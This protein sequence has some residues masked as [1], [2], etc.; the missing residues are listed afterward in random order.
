M[1]T[2]RSEAYGGGSPLL[3]NRGHVVPHFF[4]KLSF[5]FVFSC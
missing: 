1:K 3:R 5:F 4:F 2:M